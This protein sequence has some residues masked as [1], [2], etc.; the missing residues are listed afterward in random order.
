LIAEEER[1]SSDCYIFC[2]YEEKDVQNTNVLNLDQW[3]FLVV[4]TEKINEIF[5]TQ[6]SVSLSR[7]QQLGK[8]IKYDGLKREIDLV[9]DI[10]N[11][12]V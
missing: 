7:L 5:G 9:L 4:A 6:K 12:A 8:S 1:R 3:S 10:V 2:V 11:R